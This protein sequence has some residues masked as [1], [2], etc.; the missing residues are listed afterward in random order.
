MQP[1]D[2][3][4]ILESINLKMD[5]ALDAL[6]LLAVQ[7]ERIDKLETRT[8]DHEIRLRN[9]EGTPAKVLWAAIGGLGSLAVVV[10]GG[11]LLWAVGAK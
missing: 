6:T 10:I 2:K 1:C 9:V 5:R 8:D 4:P 11:Y 3:G 7:K